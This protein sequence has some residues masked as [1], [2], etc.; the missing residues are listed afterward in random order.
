MKR[1]IT[2]LLLTLLFLSA[3][4]G[5]LAAGPNGALS[6]QLYSWAQGTYT[7]AEADVVL[8]TLNGEPL[9]GDVP[10]MDLKS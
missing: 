3:L 8:L 6:I 10:A 4:L 9:E 2:A 7:P 1:I 5:T